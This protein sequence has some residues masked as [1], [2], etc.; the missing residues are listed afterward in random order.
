MAIKTY[1]KISTKDEGSTENVLCKACNETVS[2]RVF[3]SY[4]FSPIALIKPEDKNLTFAVCPNCASVYSIA[5]NYLREK[6][7]GTT[8]FLTPEDLTLIRNNNE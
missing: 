7:N 2:F 6:R 3:T 5:E 4:D 8:V 1:D